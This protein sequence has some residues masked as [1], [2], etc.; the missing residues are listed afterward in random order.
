MVEPSQNMHLLL[1]Y[2]KQMI[3]DSPGGNS[4]RQFTTFLWS[5]S[6]DVVCVS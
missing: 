3:Y 1:T 2:E 4:S 6:S 5:L